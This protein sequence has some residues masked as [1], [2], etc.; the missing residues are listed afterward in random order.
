MLRD[1]HHPRLTHHHHSRPRFYLVV[2]RSFSGHVLDLCL[3]SRHNARHCTSIVDLRLLRGN[4]TAR[5]PLRGRPRTH[6]SCDVR[7]AHVLCWW[8]AVVLGL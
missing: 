4:R 2:Q 3:A 5:F 1:R 6:L 8:C 7:W